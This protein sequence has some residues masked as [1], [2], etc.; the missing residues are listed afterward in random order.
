MSVA[1]LLTASD[2]ALLHAALSDGP[3]ALTAFKE[4]RDLTNFENVHYQAQH[5]MLPLLHSN[6]SRFNHEEDW[7]LRKI[8]GIYLQSWGAGQRQRRDAE[9]VLKNLHEAGIQPMVTKGMAL[10]DGYYG[11]I[12]LRPMEDIDLVVRPWEAERT[13]EI[14]TGMGF[15]Y[16]GPR[17]K[18]SRRARAAYFARTMQ[19]EMVKPDHTAVDLHWQPFHECPSASLSDRV[20]SQ[21][22]TIEI[23]ECK[24]VRMSPTHMLFHTITHGKRPNVFNPMRWI[25]DAA[26]I[27]ATRGGDVDWNELADLSNRTRLS[28]RVLKGL[29]ELAE[30]CDT[31]TDVNKLRF[32]PSYTERLEQRAFERILRDQ[33]FDRQLEELLW[34]RLLRFA[35]GDKWRH[36]PLI[37]ADI[38]ERKLLRNG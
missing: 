20:W 9:G 5:R 19:V 1:E 32:K 31:Q 15:D 13:L 4:W 8:K 7:L 17:L 12:G 36:L 33:G 16:F 3:K 25:A 34:V 21:S 37:S 2:C 10:V 18:G 14:L 11:N 28:I 27:L 29:E 6:L 35:Q 23:G 24:V 26:T 22:E 38:I 30:F